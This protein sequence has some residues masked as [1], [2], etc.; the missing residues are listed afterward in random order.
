MMRRAS[1]GVRLSRRRTGPGLLDAVDVGLR[2][3]ASHLSVEI[4][5]ARDDDDGVGQPVGD[6]DEIA[7]GALK[8]VFGIVEE[9]QILDLV[10][11]EDERGAI[12]RPHE[13]AE[14]GDDLEGAIL[15]VVG[16]ER[17]DGFMRDRRQLPA[18][19]ILAHALIDARIAALQIEKRAHDI[20]VELA[21]LEFFAGDD[22]VGEA[23]DQPR[24]LLVV[25]RRVA[26]LV[27]IFRRDDLGI[28]H[29]A[30]RQPRQRRLAEA[31]GVVGLF[32]RVH[33]AAQIEVGVVLHVGRHLRV[34]EVALARAM[35]VG[36]EALA[37]DGFCRRRTGRETA[38]CAPAR[39]SRGPTSRSSADR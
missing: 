2:D 31:V 36:S 33:E 14:R 37:G 19:Q 15:A 22:L 26:Q 16:I 11:A 4:F 8:T 29:H 25:E 39:D 23:Q 7:D 27:E 21:R 5:K 13:R 17:T 9:A 6:L 1:S 20:D 34:A 30:V 3:E 12:D 38:G 10:D 18:V 24:Q 32:E 35:R 28:E